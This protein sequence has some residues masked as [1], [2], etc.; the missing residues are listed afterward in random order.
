MGASAAAPSA[1]ATTA[2]ARSSSPGPQATIDVH[3]W[4]A[5]RWRAT[6]PKRS[7]GQRLF[8]HAAPGLITANGCRPATQ[9]ERAADARDDVRRGRLQREPRRPRSRT[10]RPAPA[11]ARDRRRA[12]RRARQRRGRPSAR[13]ARAGARAPADDASGAGQTREQRRL[14]QA[15]RIDR[16]VVARGPQPPHHRHDAGVAAH[17][18]RVDGHDRREAADEVEN[19]AVLHVDEPV[20]ARVGPG[21]AQRG[22]E[23]QGVDDV[24]E[25]AEPD[26]QEG[27]LARVP[28]RRRL[29]HGV[30]PRTAATRSFVE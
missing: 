28:L 7:G 23:R 29:R 15:L 12:A 24:A 26:D 22:G 21:R 10:E 1:A 4:R 18:P 20:D 11:P 9:P 25:R 27:S 30:S 14:Q 16:D 17:A 3:P 13:A 5:R 19:G 8:G 6:A 2:R